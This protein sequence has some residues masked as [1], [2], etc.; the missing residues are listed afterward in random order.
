MRLKLINVDETC[1]E[2]PTISNW[3]I[4]ENRRFSENG[5]F[6]LQIFGPIKSYHCGCSK[7]SYKGPKFKGRCPRCGVEIISCESR[8]KRHGK[9]SLPFELLNP[10]F[11]FLFTTNKNASR[12]IIDDMLSF[13]E[14]YYFDES[15]ILTKYSDEDI[16]VEKILV[17][18]YGVKTYIKTICELNPD[19][20]EFEFILNNF[21]QITMN[22]IIVIPPE[23]RPIGGKGGKKE[24]FLVDD[25]NH[26]YSQILK[27][28]GE[29]EKCPVELTFASDVYRQNFKYLQKKTIQLYEYVLDR[30]SKK[31]GIIRSNI[32]G[33]RVDF[34]GRAVISPDPTLEINQCRIPY[35]MALEILKPLLIPVLIEKKIVKR[36]NHACKYIENCIKNKDL[37]L[38]ELTQEFCKN[39]MVVINRQP[40]LHRLSV[41]GFEM[42]V[43]EGSTLKIHPM[44]C[45]AFNADFDGDAMAVY[46]P[47]TEA[48]NKDVL[49]KIG[50]WNNIISP[51]DINL[52]PQPN[53]DIILGVYTAT[54]DSSEKMDYKGIPMPIGRILFN[55]CLPEKHPVVNEV[56]NE[57]KLKAL[58]NKIAL[59]YKKSE[60]I[61]CLDNIKKLGFYYSTMEGYTISIDD[62]VDDEMKLL[63]NENVTGDYSKDN[64]FLSENKVINEKLKNHRFSSFIDSGARGS[65]QQAKQLIVMRG[66]IADVY[67]KVRPNVIKSSLA[68]GLTQ[69]EFFESSYGC[70]K[71]LLDTAVSTGDSGYL[72]RQLIYSNCNTVLGDEEDCG[73]TDYMEI[74]VKDSKMARSILWRYYVNDDGEEELLTKNNVSDVIGK[75]IKLRSPIYCRSS[76]IC[77]KCYGK[78]HTILHSNQCGTIATQAVGERATQLVLRTFHTSGA[79]SGSGKNSDN[80]DIIS[81]MNIAKKLF[82][83]P[84]KIKELSAPSEL[85]EAIYSLF[86]DYGSILM[87]HYEVIVS[88]MMWNEDERWRTMEYRED[89]KPEYVSILQVP[90]RSSWLL[91]SAFANLK[92]KLLYGLISDSIDE[93]SSIT[94][95]FRF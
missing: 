34:S 71:G 32:L 84:E 17:G 41:L 61:A 79:A 31:K 75:K 7:N 5:L 48:S 94:Q 88:S 63:I 49:D 42:L 44:I 70:R 58:L 2:L 77:K 30:M 15:G 28:I 76:K 85:V 3:K 78:L 60:V 82:H 59:S 14:S 8:K 27:M 56:V 12:K 87:V 37:S 46:F 19:K 26:H 6:S 39:R 1:K 67:N 36:Y 81:G 22:N 83:S 62:F 10:V 89:Y 11:Y 52:V 45:P 50:I 4:F 9:I 29:L 68:T 35:Y 47:M 69:K 24:E 16:P 18:L 72:T 64:E 73:T 20:P 38:L 51:T 90:T 93:T 95:M 55:K 66:Y 21:D 86:S 74:F 33:K 23:F 53:Q 65:W 80:E 40:T 13:K 43:H 91:A 25:L 54:L 92:Q 57:K